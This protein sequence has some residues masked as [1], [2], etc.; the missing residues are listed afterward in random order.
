MRQAEKGETRAGQLGRWKTVRQVEDGETGRLP[1]FFCLHIVPGDQESPS[2][3]V[4][5]LRDGRVPREGNHLH[6]L[7]TFSQ[8]ALCLYDL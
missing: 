6:G 1:V 8:N 3:R 2:D 4:D 5:R 7:A